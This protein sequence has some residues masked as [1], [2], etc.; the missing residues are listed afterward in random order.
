MT[1]HDKNIINLK[2]DG[3]HNAQD[4]VRVEFGLCI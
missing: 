1:L 4:S 2:R 3:L